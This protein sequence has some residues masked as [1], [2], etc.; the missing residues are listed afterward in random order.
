M[1]H[2]NNGRYPSLDQIYNG[3]IEEAMVQL[4]QAMGKVKDQKAVVQA[5][6]NINQTWRDLVDEAK[7][8]DP[9]QELTR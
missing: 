4:K 5:K 2:N 3:L 1:R 9:D 7:V 8:H 6:I